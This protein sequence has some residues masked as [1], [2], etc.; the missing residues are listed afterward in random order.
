MLNQLFYDLPVEELPK[1]RERVLKVSPEDIQ[2]VARWFVRPDQLSVVLVGNADQFVGSLKGAGFGT[3][4]RIPIDKLDILSADLEEAV[5]VMISCGEPSGDLY[6]GALVHALRA[7]DPQLEAFGLGGERLAGAG[8]RLVADFRGLSVTGLTEALKVLPRSWAT[9]QQLVAA[10]REQRP[11]VLVLIDY[12]D[13]NFRL[14]KRDQGA[15]H[16]DRLL[17]QPAALGLA[18]G[19]DEDDEGAGRSR[20]GDLPVR[21]GA[22]SGRRRG[23]ALRRASA[24]RAGDARRADRATLAREFGLDAHRPIVA[25]LPGSRPNE[26]TRLASVLSAAAGRDRR[27]VCRACSS[28]SPARRTSTSS[29]FSAFRVD[30]RSSRAGPTTC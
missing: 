14:M 27:R 20:A 23:R 4:E 13:F 8:A 10:A 26:L 2:R 29:L 28:S 16:P 24:P 6:A 3:Y 21:G 25:L 17:H 7:R 19:P 12:P 1:F 22:L 18:A 9:Y 11:D 5:R 15:R 30:A